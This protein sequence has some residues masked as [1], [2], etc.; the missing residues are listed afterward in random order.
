MDL[1][2]DVVVCW[3]CGLLVLVSHHDVGWSH[4]TG[5]LLFSMSFGGVS[6]LLIQSVPTCISD[7]ATV[8]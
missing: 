8:W 5:A 7:S 3:D 2:P 6:E 1:L 4:G